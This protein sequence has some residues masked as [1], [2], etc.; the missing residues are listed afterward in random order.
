MYTSQNNNLDDNNLN[1]NNLDDN[2]LNTNNLLK[3]KEVLNN[4]LFMSNNFISDL[5]E[6]EIDNIIKIKSSRVWDRLE[7]EVKNEKEELFDNLSKN[8][9]KKDI[10]NLTKI[11][12]KLSVCP[13]LEDEDLNY[14]NLLENITDPGKLK[15]KQ[16]E[17]KFKR[18]ENFITKY[19]VNYINKYI[20]ILAN[21]KINLSNDQE[22]TSHS[23]SSS[24]GNKKNKL[25]N[26]ILK[27][28]FEFL[29]KYKNNRSK[30]LFKY[31]K[32][33]FNLIKSVNK[34]KGYK[35]ITDSNDNIIT[36][37]LFNYSNSAKLL[38][39]LFFIILK[40]IINKSDSIDDDKPKKNK[41]TKTA[42]TS[43]VS[44]DEDD[45]DDSLEIG[46]NNLNIVCYFIKDI[47]KKIEEDRKFNNKYSQLSVDKNI[48]T[49][50]EES[51]DRN[52]HVMELLD[53]E[54]RR[55]R[56]EQT[57]AGLTKYADLATDFQDVI[58]KEEETNNLRDEFRKTHGDN[59][60]DELF[61][62]FK[63]NRE[64][65][66]RLENEIRLDNEIYLDAEGDDEMEI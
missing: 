10:D 30:K 20:V 41:Q 18:T 25:L 58:D 56:N 43:L 62:T 16:K 61:E 50:N 53:L 26:E 48:K 36:K 1:D 44:D 9:N 23:S 8:L 42:K 38:E 47:L 15:K 28:E 33:E 37:S 63:E 17:K 66:M 57:K 31:L 27:D 4:D 3:L 64:K 13:K 46:T 55:L 45:N 11:I 22:D 12:N 52:L 21:N 24:Y 51:K 35:D 40:S 14:I 54:T 34:I 5:V 7:Q 32:K 59:Y 39:L 6:K 49:K 60:S 29:F 65:E 2:N 19:I